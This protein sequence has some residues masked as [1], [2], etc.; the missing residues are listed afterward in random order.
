[1]KDRSLE[2]CETGYLGQHPITQPAGGHNK[3]VR[4]EAP[5]RSL[6][7]PALRLLEPLGGRDLTAEPH[8]R[9]DGEALGAAAQVFENLRLW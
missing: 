9:A 3:D 7:A 8:V 2:T 1:M 5:A 6:D 4:R